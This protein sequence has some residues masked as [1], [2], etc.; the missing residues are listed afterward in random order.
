MWMPATFC[1]DPFCGID[2][3]SNCGV[4]PRVDHM[5]RTVHVRGRFE[6][7]CTHLLWLASKTA[8]PS[9]SAKWAATEASRLT[10]ERRL[11]AD[12]V[13]APAKVPSMLRYA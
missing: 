8:I 3:R 4:Q 12:H 13:A 11:W 5:D 1:R 6:Q 2:R 7:Q 9:M 10:H